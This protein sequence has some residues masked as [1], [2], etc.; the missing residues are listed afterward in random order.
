MVIP[1]ISIFS[2]CREML[3]IT[4]NLVVKIQNLAVNQESRPVKLY[5]DMLNI[6]ASGSFMF[7]AEFLINLGDI[8]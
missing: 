5:P 3:T 1:L 4:K 7:S 2:S 6:N 8:L